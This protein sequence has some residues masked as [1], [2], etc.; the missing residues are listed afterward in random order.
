MRRNLIRKILL[1]GIC[2]QEHSLSPAAHCRKKDKYEKD[3]RHSG[4]FNCRLH[5][6]YGAFFGR[7][8]FCR[9]NAT[10]AMA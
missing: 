3:H 6:G 9:L 4:A 8:P 5:L 1:G 2:L 7:R 10:A